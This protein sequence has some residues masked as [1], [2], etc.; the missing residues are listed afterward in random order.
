MMQTSWHGSTGSRLAV[1]VGALAALTMVV[2]LYMMFVYAPPD[3]LQGDVQRILY[4]HVPLAWVAFLA[5]FVTFVGGIGYLWRRQRGWDQVARAS[6]E[7]GLVFT[8][9]VLLTGSLWGKPIW[10]TW[11]TWDARLTTTLLLWFIYLG[12]FMLRS[13]VSDPDRAA[14]YAAVLGIFG[15]VDVPIIYKSVDWW[16][17]LH[18]GPVVRTDGAA[19]PGSM[20][21]TLL[22]SLAAFTLLYAYLL[23]QKSVIERTRDEIAD[24]QYRLYERQAEREIREGATTR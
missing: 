3:D 14:R 18:P 23:Y 12:Y 9:L 2:A 7:I 11:W 20:L 10:G 5:F 22:V 13:Y 15:F 16:R 17:T 1:A 24:Y 21:A 19:M 8:T 6:A 4:L